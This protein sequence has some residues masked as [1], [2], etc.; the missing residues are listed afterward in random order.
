M[1]CN[2]IPYFTIKTHSINKTVNVMN[3]NILAN[4]DILLFEN[5]EN[6]CTSLNEES[7]FKNMKYKQEYEVTVLNDLIVSEYENED[8][9]YV[10]RESYEEYVVGRGIGTDGTFEKH[11][12]TLSEALAINLKDLGLASRDITLLQWLRECDYKYVNY[13]RNHDMEN[14]QKRSR[15]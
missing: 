4:E 13:N 15:L 12:M 3:K 9:I 11:V 8:E 6:N 2:L 10:V 14:N 1:R 7:F 5:M